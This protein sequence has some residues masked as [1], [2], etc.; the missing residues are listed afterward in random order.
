VKRPIGI[1]DSGVGGLTVLN[2]IRSRCPDI[3]FVYVADQAHVPYGERSLEEVAGFARSISRYLAGLE[4]SAIVMACNISSATALDEVS[5][6]FPETPVFGVVRAGARGACDAASELDWSVPEGDSETMSRPSIGVLATTGTVTSGAYPDAVAALC[7]EVE[8]HQVACPD[9]VPM[10]EEGEEETPRMLARCMEYLEPLADADCRVVV[11]GC[12]HY[13]LAL[14]TLRVAA[15]R[16][17]ETPPVFVDPAQV[18]AADVEA[19]VKRVMEEA[20]PDEEAS[21]L[22]DGMARLFTSGP[23]SSFRRQ[24]RKIVGDIGV[25][26]G[27]LIWQPDNTL[28]EAPMRERSHQD[29]RSFRSASSGRQRSR[30]GQPD[31]PNPRD[32]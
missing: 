6:E 12:T 19:H 17:Y 25:P 26:T 8:V 20:G 21:A 7:P 2:A 18:L 24:V 23:M 28:V 31:V 4:C 5:R 13:P 22:S 3:P 30:N 27:G 10:I 9:L 16:L 14:S 32:T 29:R 11:L 15:M 1:F